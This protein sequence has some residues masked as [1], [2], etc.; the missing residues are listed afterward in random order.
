MKF[1]GAIKLEGVFN[2]KHFREGQLL[3]EETIHNTTTNV[4]FKRVAGLINGRINGLGVNFDYLALD[5]S[6]GATA[7]ASTG[8]AIE[9]TTCGLGRVA[10]T[11]TWQTTTA[12]S[13]TAQLLK[14]F[15]ATNTKTI[16]G[17]GVFDTATTGGNMLAGTHFAGKALVSGDTLAITY[18]VKVA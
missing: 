9:C 3:S 7:A 2:I 16:Y 4:A 11:C 5:Q 1:N 12:T 13:D 18:K 17:A 14:T 6:T 8:L 10:A 15:A